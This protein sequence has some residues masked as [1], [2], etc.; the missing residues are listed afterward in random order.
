[1]AFIHSPDI[2]LDVKK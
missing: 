2:Y 1:M